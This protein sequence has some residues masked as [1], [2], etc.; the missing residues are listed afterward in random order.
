M[1]EQIA[2]KITRVIQLLLNN[3]RVYK[4]SSYNTLVS[5]LSLTNW[6]KR[7]SIQSADYGA[8]AHSFF[9]S[10]EQQ[11]LTFPSNI[12]NTEGRVTGLSCTRLPEFFPSSDNK[13]PL[14]YTQCSVHS[15]V[16]I[17]AWRDWEVQQYAALATTSFPFACHDWQKN[18]LD[19]A[20]CRS[21]GLN[22]KCSQGSWTR[23]HQP[24][25]KTNIII[26]TNFPWQTNNNR[27]W[28]CTA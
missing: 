21:S 14:I 4:A 12:Y 27:L 28:I 17:G 7:Q 22:T 1:C 23:K 24:V 2:A 25:N 20:V 11:L 13:K 10:V 19:V 5:H 26:I 9:S 8:S 3:I 15:F 18:A 16:L 6:L